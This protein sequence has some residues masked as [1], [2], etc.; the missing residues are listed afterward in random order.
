MAEGIIHRFEFIQVD[1]KHR[2]TVILPPGLGHGLLQALGKQHPVGQVGEGVVVRH[3]RSFFSV[4]LSR[5]IS[6]NTPT[7]WLFS[8]CSSTTLLRVRLRISR[9]PSRLRLANSPL[10]TPCLRAAT[11][12]ELP[13]STGSGGRRPIAVLR[14]QPVIRK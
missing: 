13:S 14:S 9:R 4:S 5:V 3:V 11:S 7:K 2:Q 10:H 8:P 12:I 1:I 6:L